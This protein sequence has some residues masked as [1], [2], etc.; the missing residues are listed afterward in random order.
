[1]SHGFGFRRLKKCK[2]SFNNLTSN[3]DTFLLDL[4]Q[5]QYGKFSRAA[6]MYGLYVFFYISKKSPG[7]V[8]FFQKI[9]GNFENKYIK[10]HKPCRIAENIIIFTV[11][12]A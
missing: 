12:I 11:L 4:Y 2:K 6:K 7:F 3:V 8:R 9:Y 1:M 5:N 10:I